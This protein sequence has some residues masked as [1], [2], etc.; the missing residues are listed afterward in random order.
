VVHF[1]GQFLGGTHQ[2]IDVV[3]PAV[4]RLWRIRPQLKDA[5]FALHLERTVG[6]WRRQTPQQVLFCRLP[7]HLLERV[8][9]LSLTATAERSPEPSVLAEF[10]AGRAMLRRL[11]QGECGVWSRGHRGAG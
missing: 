4:A 8:I 11:P 10:A 9:L 7:V 3:H 5:P 2:R 1:V 6:G